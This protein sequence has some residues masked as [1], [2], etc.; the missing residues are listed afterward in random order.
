VTEATVEEGSS[1]A[2]A[3]QADIEEEENAEAEE[4]YSILISSKPSH[5]DFEKSTCLEPMCP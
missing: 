5:L 1:G 4:D 3:E 2:E